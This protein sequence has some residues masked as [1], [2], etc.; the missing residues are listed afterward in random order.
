LKELLIEKWFPVHEASIESGRERAGANMLPP[1]YYLHIWWSRKPQAASRIAAVLSCLPADAYGRDDFKR[2]LSAMGLRGDPIKSVEAGKRS[3]GYPVFEGQNAN[4]S[5]YMG[6][7]VELWGRKPVGADFM[8]GGGS[9]PFEMARAGYGEVV[10]GE[11]SPVAYLILK[12]AVEYPAKYGDRVVR[13]VESYGKQMLRVLR[14]SVKKYYPPHPAGQPSAYIWI[15]FFRCPECGCETPSLISLWLDRVKGYAFYPEVKGD[16]VELKVVKVEEIEKIKVG[17]KNEA[18]VRITEGQLKGRVFDTNGYVQRGVLECPAHRHTIPA[19]EVKRQYR[20]ALETRERDGYHGSHPARL[21]AIVFK[22][23]GYAVPTPEMTPAYEAAETW[24][25]G[26]WES[27]IEE[28]L[29]PRE[30][31][32]VG[33]KTGEPTN[34]GINK[35][36]SL[37]NARQLIVHAEL[38]RFIRETRLR[39]AENEKRKGRTSEEAEEYGKAIATY[40]TLVLGKTLD[41]NSIIT[42]W[43][44][45]QGSINNTFKQHNFGWT[46]EYGEFD[47][48]IEDLSIA[49]SLKNVLK[50]LK[51]I[52]KRTNTASKTQ[53][54]FGDAAKI[55]GQAG[56]YDVILTDP[57]Y[58]G[59]IQYGELSDYFYVWFKRTIGDAYPEAFTTVD[60]PKSEEAVSNRVRHG[61][62]KLSSAA[63]EQKMTQIFRNT[64]RLLND[65]GVFALWFAHKA[66]EAWTT[67]IHAL[68]EAGFTI[69]SLWGVRTEMEH[70]LHISGKAALRTNIIMICRKRQASGG[71]IQDALHQLEANLEP[72]LDELESYGI[73]GPDFLMAAQAEALKAASS[74]WPLR[75]PEGKQ[76]PMEMLSHVMDIAT[77]LAVNH[78]TRKVAPQI[79]GVDAP[80]KFYVLSRYLFGDSIPYDDARR[81]ALACTGT[82]GTGDPVTEIAVDTGLADLKKEQ[83]DGTSASILVFSKPWDR[84]REDRVSTR[85]DAPVID[86]IHQAVSTLEEGGSTNKAA[87]YIA[88]AGGTVCE[89]LSA[90]Y[91]VLP[92]QIKEGR[93]TTKNLEKEHIQTLLLTVCQEGLHLQARRRLDEEHAQKRLTDYPTAQPDAKRYDPILDAFIRSQHTHVKVGTPDIDP[94]TLYTALTQRTAAR[95]LK[96]TVK[97]TL[98]GST[99]YLEKR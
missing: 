17:N 64:Y 96:T 73:V 51:G 35:W 11:Y 52:L 94:Q 38:V 9:I 39:V 63:Y 3:F 80:T 50:S 29:L 76:T 44:R 99:V 32:P 22:G 83:L 46:W 98:I 16:K 59:S 18:K 89:V 30:N 56:T 15:R 68:L 71:Y 88:Q 84:T 40:L 23:G 86:W 20:E 24:L 66:G 48:M 19:E 57:P 13:D 97:V 31:I 53:V 28:N 21:S 67:T 77:G 45:S 72:R 55:D 2:L 65:E 41:Y 27:L 90:L 10:A 58:Y 61:G 62:T 42:G 7:A 93:A 79:V 26:N 14:E 33:E 1:L 82:T 43:D 12:A 4:P 37:F 70:S 36:Y 54:I 92:D 60:T 8:A 81:L 87:E 5:A 25:K 75:D 91:Q 74:R 49:W 6:K 95:N 34:M 78:I 85:P 69:T 47:P